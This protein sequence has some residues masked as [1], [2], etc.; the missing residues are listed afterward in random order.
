MSKTLTP[1]MQAHVASE[2]TSLATCWEITRYDGV[3]LHLTDHDVDLTYDGNVYKATTGIA[4]SAVED[5]STMAVDN[6]ETK[7]IIDNDLI[8]VDDLRAGL[9]DNAEVLCFLVNHED[10]DAFGAIKIRRGWFGEL[11]ASAK[12]EVFSTDFR[13]VLAAYSQQTIKVVQSECRVDLGSL[14]CGVVLEAPEVARETAYEVDDVISVATDLGFTDGRKF[15]GIQYRCTV[16]GTT[17]LVEPA[18]DTTIGNST[19]DGTATFVAEYSFTQYVTVETVTNNRTFTI[20]L[21]SNDSIAV[22]DWFK[23]GRVVFQ[24]GLNLKASQVKN[25]TQLTREVT[26]L[27]ALP[28]TPQVGQVLKIQAGCGK[29]IDTYCLQKFNNARR[30]RGEPFVPGSHQVAQY[31]NA[32]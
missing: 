28:Y 24:E 3:V 11:Q 30:F 17:D 16:A 7:G 26:L 14:E 6:M 8:T 22:D 18:Y 31:P 12:R 25:Y 9:Y 29:T 32:V 10:P 13:G 21:P 5:T 20:S 4:R 2:V 1:A 19:V 23:Y 27:I 15:E